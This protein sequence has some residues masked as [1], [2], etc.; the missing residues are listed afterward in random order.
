VP[1]QQ[2]FGSKAEHAAPAAPTHLQ[3]PPTQLLSQHSALDV[4]VAP[5]AWQQWVKLSPVLVQPMPLQQSAALSHAPERAAHAQ[6]PAVHTPLQHSLAALHGFAVGWQQLA[7][8]PFAHTPVRHW[9]A[10]VHSHVPPAV[11][12]VLH[13][14]VWQSAFAAQLVLHVVAFAQS[15]PPPQGWVSTAGQCPAPSQ[16]RAGV[17]IPPLHDSAPQLVPAAT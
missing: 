17:S 7:T 2:K 4:Q 15:K 5:F 14:L 10:M 6:T 9:L 12:G 8:T 1:P 13:T 11:P 16:A 3:V